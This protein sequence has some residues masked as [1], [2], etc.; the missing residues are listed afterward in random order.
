MRPVAVALFAVL[1]VAQVG[2]L[3]AQTTSLVGAVTFPSKVLQHAD[4]PAVWDQFGKAVATWGNDVVI[5]VPGDDNTAVDDGSVYVYTHGGGAWPQAQK[6]TAADPVAM[7]QFGVAVDIH[8]NTMVVGAFAVGSMNWGAAYVFERI[9]GV[10]SQKQKLQVGGLP[11]NARLGW[12]VAVF[13]DYIALSAI[14]AAAVYIFQRNALP[15]N[16]WGLVAAVPA[17]LGGGAFGI[18]ISLS[19]DLLLVGASV[20]S[21]AYV[22]DRAV[23]WALVGVLSI[24]GFDAT[25]AFAKSVAIS[26][27]TAIVGAAGVDLA[28]AVPPHVNQGAAYIFQQNHGGPGAWGLVQTLVASNFSG[29]DQFGVGV[30]IG[31]DTAVVGAFA[32]D[33]YGLDSGSAYAFQRNAG[34]PNVWGETNKMYPPQ[35]GFG[36]GGQ[37]HWFGRDVATGPTRAVVGAPMY[38]NNSN[39]SKLPGYAYI[40]E[41]GPPVPS[42]STPMYVLD[43]L[44]GTHAGGG[45][46]LSGPQSP[47]YGF[48]IAVDLEVVPTG[49][50]VLDGFGGIGSGGGAA[51]ISGPATPYFAFDIAVDMEMAA[52]GYYVLDGFGG[53][54]AG[55][56]APPF[57]GPTPYFGFDI[58]ADLEL[59]GSG[60]YVLDGFGGV[61]AGGG[62]PPM[63]GPM[64]Y[65]GFDAAAD[66]E[67]FGAGYYM[68]DTFGFIHAGGGA[69]AVTTPY[70]GFH[71]A[72]DLEI[73]PV[74]FYVLD[75]WGGVHP[76]GGA[77]AINPP[78]PYWGFH[79]ARDMELK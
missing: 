39:P 20:D 68:L 14:G 70:F 10:W 74:G 72:V 50:Y 31:G 75:G 76:G 45:A 28:P 33:P 61:H 6:L 53:V 36:T 18:D 35:S 65:L 58:A 8:Q 62:A 12:R 63:P 23:N 38:A 43:G 26:G 56:G 40:F 9:G 57:S 78:M 41:L 7:D 29:Q 64:P 59:S 19:G 22:F 66:M 44:G 5:G 1:L 54:H 2:G 52:T 4:G 13:G 47:Y 51:S 27:D 71:V 24:P 37:Q 21:A 79:I 11:D 46:T 42:A 55:G 67:L 73:A 69:P 16:L 32:D 25:T 60:Y 3:S 49:Y 30:A 77:P 17:P 15:G 34:G 48:D